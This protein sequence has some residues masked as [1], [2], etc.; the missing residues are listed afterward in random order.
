MN[1]DDLAGENQEVFSVVLAVK[2]IRKCLSC[3]SGCGFLFF[4]FLPL[5]GHILKK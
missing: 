3:F 2:L 4:F 5:L 1:K